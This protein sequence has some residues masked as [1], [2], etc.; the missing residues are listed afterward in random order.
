MRIQ[1]TGISLNSQKELR[2]D[3]GRNLLYPFTE[4]PVSWILLASG[5]LYSGVSV[6]P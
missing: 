2:P 5:P 4:I 1:D 6:P 3:L